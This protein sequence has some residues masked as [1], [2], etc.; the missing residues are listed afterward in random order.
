MLHINNN[1][2]SPLFVLGKED[3]FYVRVAV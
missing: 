1:H 2:S 3:M